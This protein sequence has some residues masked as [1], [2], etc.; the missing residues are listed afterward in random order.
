MTREFLG[1]AAHEVSRACF[2]V[3]GPVSDE[4]CR[5][6]NLPW[7]I[8]ARQLE[9]ELSLPRVA[10]VNDFHA[11]S[12]GIGELPAE[13]FVTLHDTPSDPSGPWVVIGAGTGLGQAVLVKGAA[14]LEVLSSEG[15][16]TEFGP[17][18]ELEIE[19]LRFLL[20]RHDHVSYERLVSGP[21]LKTIYDFLREHGAVGESET[22]RRELAASPDSGPAIVS[23]HGLAGDDPLCTKALDLFAS[24]YGAEAGNLALKVVARGGVYVAGGIAPKILPKLQDGTFMKAFL[25]KGR[26]GHVLERVRVRVVLNSDAGLVG[27]AAIARRLE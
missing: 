5:A 2:G 10:L 22:V 9:R 1:S 15:G 8:D 4:V 19:L 11:L 16:H 18:N 20:A 14:G 24:L 13:D 7:I 17:R 23:A 6:T 3:A 25:D 21:G 27:A 26:L 12:I